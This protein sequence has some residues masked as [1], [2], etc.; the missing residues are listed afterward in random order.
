M[1]EQSSFNFSPAP[2]PG[3]LFK[4][5]SQQ[6]KVYEGLLAGGLTS[7]QIQK[8]GILSHTRRIS[9]IREKLQPH[10][11]DVVAERQQGRVYFYKIIGMKENAA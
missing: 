2:R 3:E 1:T 10:L 4:W 5:G 11:M 9:D 7:V 6:Y 8:M